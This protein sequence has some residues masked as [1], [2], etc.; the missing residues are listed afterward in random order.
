MQII[1]DIIKLLDQFLLLFVILVPTAL[2]GTAAYL[3]RKHYRESPEPTFTPVSEDDLHLEAARFFNEADKGLSAIG[4][5]RVG[6]FMKSRKRIGDYDTQI[7]FRLFVN[8]ALGD[9]AMATFHYTD[10]IGDPL[11]INARY[12]EFHSDFGKSLSI[13]TNNAKRPPICPDILERSVC[14]HRTDDPD[15][16]YLLHKKHVFDRYGKRDKHHLTASEMV[17]HVHDRA[18]REIAL[19][20]RYGYLEPA[21]E[22]EAYRPTWIG[23]LKMMKNAIIPY[24]SDKF[25]ESDTLTPVEEQSI[26]DRYTRTFRKRSGP[27]RPKPKVKPK[28]KTQPKP[29]LDLIR[30]ECPNCGRVSTAP[31]HKIPPA[32]IHARCAGC[33]QRVFIQMDAEASG[34]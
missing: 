1:A 23:S 33:G 3:F 20:R 10:R 24:F 6:D 8:E 27:P 13:D 21:G 26:Q 12:I 15:R 7:A 32:G 31:S 29:A 28:S 11:K 25:I 17:N 22:S 34:E 2:V 14:T 30:V 16:L 19:M 5:V 9:A 18:G 4:F